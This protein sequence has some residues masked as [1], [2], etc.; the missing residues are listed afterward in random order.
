MGWANGFRS[1]TLFKPGRPGGGMVMEG[2]EVKDGGMISEL[3][4]ALRLEGIE[5]EG[6]PSWALMGG[7]PRFPAEAGEGSGTMPCTSCLC[8]FK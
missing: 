8:F 6:F 4:D 7:L 1:M 5:M 2:A 3:S